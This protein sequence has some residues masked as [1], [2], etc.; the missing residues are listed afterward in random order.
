MIGIMCYDLR[1]ISLLFSRHGIT[2]V[3]NGLQP[4]KILSFRGVNNRGNIPRSINGC[5]FQRMYPC[6]AQ[7]QPSGGQFGPQRL[8]SSNMGGNQF[9]PVVALKCDMSQLPALEKKNHV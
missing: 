1:C 9:L 5:C 8:V 3:N 4:T 7:K 2:E 6:T